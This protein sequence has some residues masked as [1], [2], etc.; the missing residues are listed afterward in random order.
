MS[1]S[2]GVISRSM[3]MGM[4]VGFSPTVGLQLVICLI[5]SFVANQFRPSTFNTVIALV[6]SLVVNP[7]TMVPTYTF[8]YFLGCQMR[9]C[10][11]PVEFEHANQIERLLMTGGD[12]AI[13]IML[14]SIP[15]MVVGLPVGWWL[16]RL[17]EKFL[18][19]R[20]EVRR[21]R[22]IEN[23]RRKR[24]QTVDAD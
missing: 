17:V 5:L 6:G 20:K 2:N 14:G 18:E 19:R 8:Y 12:G 16:G 3:S 10:T 21:A 23:A 22:L 13:T 24:E 9:G 1:L 15:F 11:Q 4:V 7:F